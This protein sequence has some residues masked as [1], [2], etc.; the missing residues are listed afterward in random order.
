MFFSSPRLRGLLP[1]LAILAFAGSAAAHEYKIGALSVGHP[2]ARE[3]PPAAIMG[4]GYLTV[5]NSGTEADTLIA[6]ETSGAQK[7]E[8]HQ[9][10]VENGVA[11]MRPVTGVEIPAGGEVALAPGGYH[12]M[13]VGLKEAL[14]E[15]MRIP[16]TLTFAKAGKID[17]ELAVEN[18]GYSGP[19]EKAGMAAPAEEHKHH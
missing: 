5:K 2:W 17:V 18:M 12:L 13:L 19:G 7:V 6:V 10:T 1:I 15:G 16:A 11:K 8:M 9:S 14:A 3:T 4:A